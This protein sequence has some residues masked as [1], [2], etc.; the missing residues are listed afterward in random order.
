MI[1]IWSPSPQAPVLGRNWKLQAEGP[2]WGRM[3][4]GM[5]CWDNIVPGCILS[6]YLRPVCWEVRRSFAALLVPSRCQVTTDRI[7]WNWEP[8]QVH[9]SSDCSVT[10]FATATREAIATTASFVK[11]QAESNG[12]WAKTPLGS[13]VQS[14]EGIKPPPWEFWPIRQSISKYVS[15][16]LLCLVAW[17]ASSIDWLFVCFEQVSP[18]RWTVYPC[19]LCLPHRC[20]HS[21]R[22]RVEVGQFPWLRISQHQNSELSGKSQPDSSSCL[23]PTASL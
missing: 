21:A 4:L 12:I 14:P 8:K 19:S 15:S 3:S 20:E 16:I 6:L 18:V 1:W 9:L 17:Y 23:S 11:G 7:L 10:T 2:C 22:Y 13:K 5:D